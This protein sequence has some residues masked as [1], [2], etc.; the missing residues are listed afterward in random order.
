MLFLG[1]SWS[2]TLLRCD[3][4]INLY[5]VMGLSLMFAAQYAYHSQSVKAS[6]KQRN[7]AVTLYIRKMQY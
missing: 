5:N 4:S 3:R 2:K 6:W 7:P 1:F